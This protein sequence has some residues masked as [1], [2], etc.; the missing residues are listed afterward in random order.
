MF[1]GCMPNTFFKIQG[2]QGLLAP[3]IAFFQGFSPK[4]L[5]FQGSQDNGV[6]VHVDER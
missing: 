2:F 3:F 6:L 4:M 1:T 5:P